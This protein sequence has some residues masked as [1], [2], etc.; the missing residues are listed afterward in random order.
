MHNAIWQQQMGGR[1]GISCRRVYRPI[2]PRGSYGLINRLG[3][4]STGLRFGLWLASAGSASR[5]CP[6]TKCRRRNGQILPCGRSIA[7]TGWK[8]TS[9]MRDGNSPFCS[10]ITIRIIWYDTVKVLHNNTA[11][12]WIHNIIM[13]NIESF[14]TIK[15]EICPLVNYMPCCTVPVVH[16]TRQTFFVLSSS[17]QCRNTP[18]F[19]WRVYRCIGNHHSYL[20]CRATGPMGEGKSDDFLLLLCLYFDRFFEGLWS[21]FN[22]GFFFWRIHWSVKVIMCKCVQIYHYFLL[23]TLLSDVWSSDSIRHL[24]ELWIIL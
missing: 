23:L 20:E 2:L 22:M 17:A 12:C 24:T 14:C 11:E 16:V 6:M 15:Y 4:I 19:S 3:D 10:C 9:E 21:L 18:R 8:T 5:L 13:L 1:S 7:G